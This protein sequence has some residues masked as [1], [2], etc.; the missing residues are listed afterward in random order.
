MFKRLQYVLNAAAR[1]VL[2]LPACVNSDGREAA[3]ARIST[4]SHVQV[5]RPGL[6]RSAWIGTRL[7]DQTMCL[8]SRRSWPCT[9][10]PSQVG[11]RWTAHDAMPIT[12][13]KTIGDKG[14][15]HCGPVKSN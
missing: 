10:Q 9:S 12:N 3:L 8:S 7:L 2:Q 4:S 5:V 1:L 11:F 14:F 13:K 6:Q 15:S